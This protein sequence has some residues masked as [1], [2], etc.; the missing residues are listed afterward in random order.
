MNFISFVTLDLCD[1]HHLHVYSMIIYHSIQS[2]PSGIKLREEFS[3]A[4]K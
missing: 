3:S 2:N 4:G 1:F